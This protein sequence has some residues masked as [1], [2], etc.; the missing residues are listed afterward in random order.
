MAHVIQSFSSQT[1]RLNLE[2]IKEVII[3]HAHPVLVSI[4]I[5]VFLNCLLVVLI[6][7]CW[8]IRATFE[9]IKIPVEPL[10]RRSLLVVFHIRNASLFDHP[11]SGQS[12]IRII[13][14][15]K[16]DNR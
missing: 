2:A 13:F 7:L 9:L 11:K 4:L 15:L 10:I 3:V 14:V 8:Y 1:I 6:T 12:E 16:V 5:D